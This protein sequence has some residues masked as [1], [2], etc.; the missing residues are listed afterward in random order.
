MNI[1]RKNQ[2]KNPGVTLYTYHIRQELAHEVTNDAQRLWE[3][4]SELSKPLGIPELKRLREQLICYE[5][6]IYTPGTENGRQPGQII[7]L[8]RQDR[9][10][11]FQKILHADNLILSGFL[12]PVK[13]H[14]TYTADLTLFFKDQTTDASRFGLFNPG[15]CLLSSNIFANMGQT[16]L[17]FATPTEETPAD[18][19]LADECVKAFLKDS[20]QLIPQFTGDGRLFGSPIFEYE[21]ESLNPS[22]ECHILVWF[23]TDS[24]TSDL[25]DKAYNYLMNLLCCRSKII[26]TYNESRHCNN[27]ARKLYSRLEKRAEILSD[28]KPEQPEKRLGNLETLLAEMPPDALDYACCLRDMHD[29]ITTTE[30]NAKNYASW[31]DDIRTLSNPEHEDDLRFL[32][33]FH[34]RACCQFHEQIQTDLRYLSPG[35]NLFEEIINTIRGLVEIDTLKQ[36]KENEEKESKH[37]TN[38]QIFIAFIGFVLAGATISAT[39]DAGTGGKLLLN[40]DNLFGMIFSHFFLAGF[41]LGVLAILVLWLIRKIIP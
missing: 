8:I 29:F 7:E 19:T 9:Y 14:D 3:N 37:Q 20:H 28:L 4:L 40:I 18:K 41:P 38:L 33:H 31:L 30:T 1:Q 23:N 17:L 24:K 22:E 10:L 13:L 26:F 35:Q 34:D 6:G 27:K 12:Y 16:L 36:L 15:G 21:T 2:I 32:E 25:A 39:L 11:K 5:N